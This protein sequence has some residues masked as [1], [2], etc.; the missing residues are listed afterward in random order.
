MSLRDFF[1]AAALPVVVAID[2]EYCRVN[3]GKTG[4]QGNRDDHAYESYQYADAM[5][6]AGGYAEPTQAQP[7]QTAALVQAL[8]DL[9]RWCEDMGGWEAPCW[10]RAKEAIKAAALDTDPHQT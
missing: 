3:D 7:D 5:L 10:D 2:R 6:R 1:A 8:K 4:T 9:V